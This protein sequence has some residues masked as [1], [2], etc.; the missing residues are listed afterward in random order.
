[1]TIIAQNIRR[2]L[3]RAKLSQHALASRVGVPDRTVSRWI[4]GHTTP[5]VAHLQRIAA[6][7]GTTLA[8]LAGELE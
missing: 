1:M 8:T 7:L 4:A 6:A 3:T 2:E 5:S